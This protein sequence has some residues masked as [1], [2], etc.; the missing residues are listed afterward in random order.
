[1]EYSQGLTLTDTSTND[2]QWDDFDLD[3]EDSKDILPNLAQGGV[4]TKAD[5]VI[6]VDYKYFGI[7]NR[8]MF[9]FDGLHE[10]KWQWS[11]QPIGNRLAEF[12]KEV[13]DSLK[14]HLK[15]TTLS[16]NG[17]P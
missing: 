16:P 17:V 11:K 1:L 9:R 8:R 5:V 7:K 4:L 14:K 2:L 3:R 6:G 13:D 15:Y 10:E 12:S